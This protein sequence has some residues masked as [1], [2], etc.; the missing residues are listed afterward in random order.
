MYH[1]R[2]DI[3]EDYVYASDEV[4]FAKFLRDLNFDLQN[5][6]EGSVTENGYQNA[7]HKEH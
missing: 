4:D 2:G 5:A 3:Y 7:T 6:N 1:T